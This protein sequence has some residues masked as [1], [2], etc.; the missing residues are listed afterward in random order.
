MS[1][2][3]AV[4]LLVSHP[5]SSLLRI[6]QKLRN[7]R[8]QGWARRVETRG[9]FL[10]V[11]ISDGCS[12]KTVQAVIQ[13]DIC[14]KLP[15]GSAVDI[16]G[17]WVKSHGKKQ[18]MELFATNCEIFSELPTEKSSADVT[19]RNYHL[20]MKSVPFMCLIRL[21]SRLDY[22]SRSFFQNE[23]FIHVDAP[24]LTHNDCEGGGEVFTVQANKQNYFGDQ[25]VYLTVSS[26]LYLEAFASSVPKVYTI[27]P[28]LRADH[29]QTRQHL[30]EF[31]MLEAEYAF[32]D[33]LHQLCDLVERYINYVVDGMLNIAMEEINS[34]MEIF[35]DESAREKSLLWINGPR[36][37][38]PRIYYD[39]A[40]SILQN[41]GELTSD[42]RFS[43]ENELSLVQH[44][45]GPLFI[46]RY[47]HAQKPFYMKRSGNYAE[48]FDLLAPFVGELAG[49]SLRESN[50]E[51][52]RRRG[53]DQ[54]LDWYL[55]IRGHGHPPSAGFGIGLERLMQAL[56]GILN[57][58]DTV[59]FPRW[60]V[61]MDILFDEG[62]GVVTES[63]IYAALCKQI[64][65]LFGDYGMAAAKLSLT[66]KVFDIGTATTIV[67][68]SKE[69]AQRLLSAIP[70]VC[71]INDKPAVLQVLFVGS[72][73]RSCQRA[74]L[75][76]NRKHLY[77]NYVAAKTDGEKK[78]ILEA[79]R[80]VTGNVK[81]ENTLIG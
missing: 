70:F 71:S 75:R 68:I 44:F 46:L 14:P 50:P 29:S 67:R 69:F 47:P 60:Y 42:N 40:I 15:V 23:S 73:I 78:D 20:R 36:K 12:L 10:F 65:L 64:E 3:D 74:L 34:V 37:P 17:D 45:G 5:V 59:A 19:R 63:A 13:R 2:K 33:D 57:I 51:E 38:F 8:I 81:F 56:F 41:K 79:I 26:Q 58:K 6:E 11:N 4:K 18:N 21:R 22:L 52:L 76:I 62:G 61:L 72:S 35:C 32:A 24:L 54:S 66:V 1:V 28:A 43:K 48:C 49:G 55:E 16:V 31:R 77:S 30:A 53:C 80:S 27:A 9:K 25:T 39:E 7:I